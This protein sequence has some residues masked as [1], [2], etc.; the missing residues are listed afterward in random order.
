MIRL[1]QPQPLALGLL[2]TSVVA[3]AP[4]RASAQDDATDALCI[5]L[6]KSTNS[7]PA[8]L[9]STCEQAAATHK[10]K[11]DRES[12]RP[13]QVDLLTEATFI[14]F[15]ARGE[16]GSGNFD[17][18]LAELGKSLQIYENVRDHAVDSDIR[19]KANAGISTVTDTVNALKQGM[20]S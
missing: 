14:Y 6:F 19:S 10:A 13:R 2:V 3:S 8:A 20:H 9:A 5:T 11:A 1:R 15:S 7:S 16:G 17:L 4:V 12:G 18:A